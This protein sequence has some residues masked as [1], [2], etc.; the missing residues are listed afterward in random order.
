M[1]KLLPRDQGK[2]DLVIV[3][4][5]SVPLMVAGFV[6]AMIEGGFAEPP[7]VATPVSTPYIAPEST[8]TFISTPES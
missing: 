2:R 5:I 8:P 4:L 6:W 7:P 1:D 3:A